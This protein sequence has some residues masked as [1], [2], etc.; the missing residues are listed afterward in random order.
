MFIGHFGLGF[1][2][3]RLAPTVSLGTLFIACQFADLLWPFLV[4]S[5]IEVVKITPGITVMTPLEFVS[6]PYSHSL[7]MLIVW[8]ILFALAY[9]IARKGPVKA[10]MVL[11][12]LVVSHWVLDVVMHLPDM[13]LTPA[14][15]SP[16][17]GFTLWNSRAGTLATEL[18]LFGAGIWVYLRSTRARDRIGKYGFWVL[19][20]LLLVFYIGGS[21]G[22]PPPNVE[23]VGWG[24]IIG[25][26]VIIALAY[27]VDHHRGADAPK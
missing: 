10:A 24:S 12:A 14:A 9:H 7:V 18:L 21:F 6:Y 2:A 15:G 23:T 25:G 4:L 20:A 8:G 27:W 26:L 11:G 1:A 19:V 3:K 16:R 5:G 22:P 13:P 17:F